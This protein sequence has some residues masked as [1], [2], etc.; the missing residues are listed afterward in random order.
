M[1]STFDP[2]QYT[3]VPTRSP[4]STL[5][6]SR[7]LLSAAPKRPGKPIAKRLV[8]LRA[9]AE[10]LQAAWVDTS[11]PMPTV[12]DLRPFDMVLD[13]RWKALRSRLEGCFLLGDEDRSARAERMMTTLFPTGLD[14]L[15]LPYAEEWAQSERRL[16]LVESE[17]LEEELEGLV[18][19]G[20]LPALRQAHEAY[21]RALGITERKEAAPE[22]ARVLEPLRA[23]KAAIVGYARGVVGVVDEDD[24][25][26]VRA[27]QHQLEPILRARRPRGPGASESEEPVDAPLPEAPEVVEL[28]EA[29]AQ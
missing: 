27:A 18:G 11:R 6:L 25:E 24:A 9:A 2:D 10:L 21:G 3:T 28:A 22:A 7:A 1:S 8:K 5:S 29:A 13:R 26:A 23:L 4:A 16:L 17:A 15:T 12:E 20:Y 14:F 19:E